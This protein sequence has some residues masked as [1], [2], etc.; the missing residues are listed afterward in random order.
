MNAT[1]GITQWMIHRLWKDTAH[2][3]AVVVLFVIGF[4]SLVRSERIRRIADR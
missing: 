4:V 2:Q 1:D 3:A